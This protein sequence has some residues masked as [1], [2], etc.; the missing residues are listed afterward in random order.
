[1]KLTDFQPNNLYNGSFGKSEDSEIPLAFKFSDGS[2]GRLQMCDSDVL[3]LPTAKG[4][5]YNELSSKSDHISPTF[6]SDR[7]HKLFKLDTNKK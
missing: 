6:G 5:L 1:M 4:A 3:K 2:V 7:L